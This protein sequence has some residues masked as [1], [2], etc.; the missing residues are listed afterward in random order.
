MRVS[1]AWQGWQLSVP[2]SWNVTA[3]SGNVSS[4]HALL[5]DLDGPRLGIRWKKVAGGDVTRAFVERVV[6]DEVGPEAVGRVVQPP[7]DDAGPAGA[8]AAVYLDPELPP[9]DVYAAW[10]PGSGRVIELV[11][12]ALQRDDV[13]MRELVPS[14]RDTTVLPHQPWSVL[15][16]TCAV[17]AGFELRSH[18]LRAGDLQL[19][20]AAGRRFVSVRQLALAEM[21]LKRTTLEHLVREQQRRA[22]LHYSPDDAITDVQ[23]A[24]EGGRELSGR[25]GRAHRRRRF[26]WKA[27]LAPQRVTLALHDR[28]RDRIV[29]VEAD[30]WELARDV[31]LTVGGGL[32]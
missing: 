1:F 31:A 15:D 30:K 10:A 13:L 21:A 28:T 27:R 32:S 12:H 8:I 22:H 20:W 29:I 25:L 2:A 6:R 11:Y 26:F 17:P 18:E 19:H 3:L 23:L 7:A 14:I 5:A 24:A 16:L 4:G 9:R